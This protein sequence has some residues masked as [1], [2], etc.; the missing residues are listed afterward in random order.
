MTFSSSTC[1]QK[2]ESIKGEDWLQIWEI[3]SNN[4][5]VGSLDHFPSFSR[6]SY[7]PS[8]RLFHNFSRSA[9]IN[10]PQKDSLFALRAICGTNV[11][12]EFPCQFQ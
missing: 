2:M 12:S 9:R 8:G 1:R 3:E 6:F 10:E 7:L 4:S 5:N 11:F